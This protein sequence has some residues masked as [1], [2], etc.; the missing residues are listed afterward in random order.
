MRVLVT[1]GAG[2][3]GSH[4][5]RRLVERGYSVRVLDNF[6]TGS[7]ENIWDVLGSVELVKGDVRDPETVRRGVEGVEAVVHLAALISVPESVEK[8]D[9]YFD[10]NV[11]GTYNISKAFRGSVLVFASS[12]SVYGEPQHL[13][14]GEG[15]PLNPKSP[16]AASKIAGEAFTLSFSHINGYRPVVLRIFNAYG[17]GQSRAYAGVVSEFISR[18]SVGEP[19]VIYGDGEQTRDFIHV[20]DVVE[21]MISAV[22]REEARGVYNIGSGREVKIRELARIILEAF[23]RGD[24]TPIH[25]PPREGDVRRSCADISLAA[26]DLAWKPKIRLEDGVRELVEHARKKGRL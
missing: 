10:V 3:I 17:P 22:E 5:V 25:A 20:S 19:P 1:G 14:V 13:P 9:L 2:F 8:P 7:I 12:S 4:L 26:R 23:G 11:K 15:H 6:S 16:Y 21:A 18:V 24:L